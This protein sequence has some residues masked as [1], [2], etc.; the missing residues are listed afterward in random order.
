[1]AFA[2]RILMIHET[3]AIMDQFQIVEELDLSP[4]QG[5]LNPQIF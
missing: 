2:G 5:C 4:F 1:M 3:A